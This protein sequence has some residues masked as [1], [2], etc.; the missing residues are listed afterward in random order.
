M[1][2]WIAHAFNHAC[3]CSSILLSHSRE[4]LPH[5]MSFWYP[6]YNILSLPHSSGSMAKMIT[7]GDDE[8][9]IR[10]VFTKSQWST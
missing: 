7:L 2:M 10:K 5:L 4:T 6:A 3:W 9:P 8:K 1:S